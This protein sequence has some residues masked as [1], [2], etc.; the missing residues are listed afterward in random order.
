MN[1]QTSKSFYSILYFC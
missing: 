1:A